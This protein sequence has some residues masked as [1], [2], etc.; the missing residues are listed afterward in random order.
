MAGEGTTACWSDDE[1]EAATD[2][3]ETFDF[4]QK[5]AILPCTIAISC[6]VFG[7]EFQVR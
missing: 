6:F 7:S 5:P 2:G 1:D 4:D 3:L